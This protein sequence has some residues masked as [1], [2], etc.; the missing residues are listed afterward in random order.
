MAV[1]AL[2]AG[3]ALAAEPITF[4]ERKLKR[5]VP[6]CE[7]DFRWLEATSLP[8]DVRGRINT[9]IAASFFKGTQMPDFQK[10]A[11]RFIKECREAAPHTVGWSLI[12]G[13]AAL[14]TRP[15]VVSVEYVSESY[16]GG[17][18]PNAAR[19]FLNLDPETGRPVKLESIL[20]EGALPR[21]TEIAE[22]HFRAERELS[23]TA[24]LKEEGFWWEDGRFH[25]N[26]NYGFGENSITFFYN[27]YEVA[28]YA[29]GPTEVEIPYSEILD[30]LRPEFRNAL[31]A[32]GT[33]PK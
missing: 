4:A 25:L 27:Q 26:D 12:I 24:N 9:A 14:R 19:W 10:E 28:P 21:L 16:E 1:A 8:P 18:H 17:A 20:T 2:A 29:M 13:M 22:R 31:T 6:G 32:P 7:Q 30:L 11:D 23:P 15:P 5:S 3:C 33:A